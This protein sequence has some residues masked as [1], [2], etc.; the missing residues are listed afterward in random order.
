MKKIFTVILASLLFACVANAEDV[1]YLNNG[2][3][4]KGTVTKDDGTTVEIQ[5]NGNTLQYKSLEIRKIDKGS[6]AIVMPETPK[7]PKYVDYETAKKGYWTAV[8]IWG[9]GAVDF[10]GKPNMCNIDV[11]WINGYRFNEWIRIGVGLGFRYY[12]GDLNYQI[13]GNSY[14][15]PISG[16]YGWEKPGKPNDTQGGS[17]WALPLYLDLRGNIMSMAT[18][19]CV[20]Y[21]SFDA[22]YTFSGNFVNQTD[23]VK[24]ATPGADPQK[25]IDG[26]IQLG[27]GFFFAPTLGIK[28]MGPRHSLLIGI[29]Y[30]GQ[31]LPRYASYTGN[32]TTVSTPYVTPQYTNFL[33]GKIAYEF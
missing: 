17:Q 31:I 24:D 12:L 8:E 19:M 20:P 1:I 4:I 27:Q 28:I 30:M 33:M 23:F 22:G 5:S 25:E 10:G 15:E 3:V 21:W 32:S 2:K 29:S 9:G 16:K 14:P 26:K 13:G 18:R 6:S 11:H 7:R